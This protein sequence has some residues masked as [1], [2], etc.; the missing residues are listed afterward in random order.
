MKFNEISDGPILT[1]QCKL[2][3]EIDSLKINSYY[4]T[5]SF[6]T[7][8]TKVK[9]D[10]EQEYKMTKIAIVSQKLLRDVIII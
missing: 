3:F 8:V 10:V 1:L 4:F 5:S 9:T 6:N 7:D 2:Q